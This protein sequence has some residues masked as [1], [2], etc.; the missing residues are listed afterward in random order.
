MTVAA[1]S[2][3]TDTVRLTLDDAIARARTH[4]VN[5]AVAL[6]ELRSA[7]WQYRTYRAELLPEVNLTATVPSYHKQYSSYMNADGTYSFVRNNFLQMNGG[8]SITQNVWLT[9]AQLSVTPRS[10]GSA[11][12]RVIPTTGS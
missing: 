11:N 8:L 7:Y 2:A 1:Q 9:G 10:T 4:S 12:W 3:A 6:D 5:A